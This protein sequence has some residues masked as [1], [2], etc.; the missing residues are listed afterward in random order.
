MEAS[1]TTPYRKHGRQSAQVTFSLEAAAAKS[2]RSLCDNFQQHTE[3]VHPKPSG[4]AT[5]DFASL[6]G[7]D[8]PANTWK[9]VVDYIFPGGMLG[10][11]RR[12]AGTARP[13]LPT[14]NG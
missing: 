12:A 6:R 14:G 4:R 13:R 3:A 9:S 2:Y 5:R 7:S 11:V 8:R 10:G 1:L